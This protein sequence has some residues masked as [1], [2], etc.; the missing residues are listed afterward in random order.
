MPETSLPKPGDY[1][2][3]AYKGRSE[4]CQICP[5]LKTFDDGKSHESEESLV[6]RDGSESIW[7]VRTAPIRDSN[8]EIAAVMEISLDITQ[9]KRLEREIRKSEEKYYTIFDDFPTQC[10]L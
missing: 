7:L 6:N 2:F 8:R 3:A 10:L 1:C 5:V 9:L 4:P